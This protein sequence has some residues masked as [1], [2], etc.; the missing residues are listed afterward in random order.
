MSSDEHAK[1]IIE[2]SDNVA[3]AATLGKIPVQWFALN[4]AHFL[5]A[6]QRAMGQTFGRHASQLDGDDASEVRNQHSTRELPVSQR[7]EARK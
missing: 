7:G 1:I 3:R 2:L 5:N 4:P 6:M